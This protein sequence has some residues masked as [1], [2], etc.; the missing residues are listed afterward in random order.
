MVLTLKHCRSLL[1]LLLVC[2]LFPAV[3]LQAQSSRFIIKGHVPQAA[4]QAGP[5]QRLPDTNIL[6]LALGL[7]LRNKSALAELLQQLYDPSSPNF[8][9]YLTPVEFTE[10]FGPTEADYMAVQE[11]ARTNGLRITTT[12][13][14][15]V[16]LD[17]EGASPVVERAFQIQLH[18]YAHPTEGRRFY[19]P[20]REPSVTAGLPVLHVSGLD[21]FSLPHPR[22]RSASATGNNQAQPAAGSAPGGK[23]WGKDFRAAY[24]PGSPLTG[25]GQ[26]VGL[27]QFD[28][29]KA[30][31]ILTYQTNAGLPG[32]ALTVVKVDGG[33]ATPG[34]GAIEVCLDIE[35]VI[36]MAPGLSGVFVYE[37]PNPS[38]WVDLLNAMVVNTAVKQFSCSWGG[39]S[40]DPTAEGIF[41]QMAAQGQSFFNA[42]GDSDAFTNSIPFPGDSPNITQVG[43]TTLSTGSGSGYVSETVWNWGGGVGS[44]GGIS[45]Y[46]GLPTYQQGLATGANQGS[47]TRRN[48][49]DVALVADGIYVFSGG[50]GSTVGGTSAAAPLW[51]GFMALVNQQ[52]TLSGVPVIGFAN[53]VLY[54]LARSASYASVFHDITNG[55][56]FSGTSPTHFSATPGYDLATGLG[57]PN[58][59]NLINA[60]AQP[61]YFVSLTN[62]N[63]N[64]LS[65]SA[66]PANGSIDPGETV[67]LSLSVQNQGTLPTANLVATLL[68]S[69]G[70][71]APSGSQTYGVLAGYG[72]VTNK[73]FTLTTAGGCGSNITAVL[74]L[75]DGTNYLGTVS[76]VLPLGGVSTNRIQSFAQNFDGVIAP[77][78]PE[79]WSSLNVLGTATNWQTRSGVFHTGP[80]SAFVA[81]SEVAGENAL[82]SPVISVLGT[83]AQLAF[84]HN[85]S[86]EYNTTIIGF[87]RPRTYYTNYDGG[88]LEIQIGS[89]GFSDILSAGGSFRSGGYN[90]AITVTSDNPLGGQGGWVTNSSG[91]QSV[92]VNLPASAARQ[93]VQLRWN[94]ATDNGNAGL[95]AVGWYVDS[96]SITDAVLSCLTVLTDVAAGQSLS[97]NSLEAGRNLVYTLSVTN[98]GPQPAANVILTD[99]LPSGSGFIAA[100]SGG[101]YA[102]G[103]IVFPL[104][105][106]GVGASTNLTLTLSSPG[107]GAFTNLVSVG[108]VTPESSVENNTL[109]LVST[110]AS[111]IPPDLGSGLASC[112]VECGSNALFSITPVG[113]PPLALQWSLDGQV[114]AGATNSSISLTNLHLP[115]HTVAIVVTN[116]YGSTT[117]SV[118]VTMADTVAPVITLN[119]VGTVVLELGGVWID[120]GATASDLCAGPVVVVAGGT[121]NTAVPGTNVLTYSASDGNGNAGSITRTVVVRDTVPPQI[122]RCFTNL[123]LAADSSCRAVMPEITGT[124]FIEAWDLSGA[125]TVRQSPTNLSVLPLGTTVAVLTVTDG[126]GNAAYATNTIL[127]QDQTPP[128]IWGQPIGQTNIAAT[129][130]VLTLGATAC[131]PIHY[132]WYFH[133]TALSD[134]TNSSLTISNI[135]ALQAG[136]YSAVA[137]AAGGSSTSAVASLEV[138][139]LPIVLTLTASSNPVGFRDSVSFGIGLAPANASGSVQLFTNGAALAPASPLPAGGIAIATAALPRG[140]QNVTAVY[141]GDELYL[142]ATNSLVEVVTN[143]PPAAVPVTYVFN[144]GVALNIPLP[145]L[146]AG[147]SDP[148]GDAL[149][150]RDLGVST[151]GITLTNTGFFLVYL[152]TNSAPDYFQCL[153]GDEFGGSAQQAVFLVKADP[154]DPTPVIRSGT[155]DGTGNFNLILAGAPGRT[156]VLEGT[157]GLEAEGSWMPFTT[158]VVD[159]SGIWV[160]QDAPVQGDLQRFYRLKLIP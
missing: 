67:T 28:G 75:Q 39:G 121:V 159:A 99:T 57:T 88:V 40:P 25:A 79:G 26:Y 86:F 1:F 135:T 65:E 147:W 16:V 34:S 54:S 116:L 10:R 105:M 50:A 46:Y 37:A 125:V 74:Q 118:L 19:A 80:N 137:S 63:W 12:H 89:G 83:N 42:S 6:H 8:H 33:V 59:T 91:W 148:D 52:A 29:F 70:V 43:G 101:A 134:A 23:Y 108:T 35:M 55:N 104:G 139:R 119:G 136:D 85:Y 84:R 145:A 109:Q 4:A 5:G 32:V 77:T 87:S 95:G 92:L 14:N 30:S 76:Y 128:L 7:P 142:P 31:D 69:S 152:S 112:L 158:N 61:V 62:G 133:Q 82:V 24:A 114:I 21:N 78:L 138:Q 60:L 124:N 20:D 90:G 66:T 73:P 47:S 11:F 156:Y 38:P 113:T 72:G 103:V 154:V 123:V 15:R 140:S 27:L 160:F 120:P 102:D 117:G 68:S 53:P 93:N 41:Q 130:A 149:T 44:S 122:L 98:L 97:T 106:L 3:S 115:N 81:D 155:L 56:N 22:L 153:V 126:S 13:P 18:H 17:V 146:S 144:P 94:C 143:H 96:V 131:T 71:L 132:Q 49:P 45:P 64:L 107:G 111:G 36:S 51:A 9:R 151:N 129:V 141:S 127:V 157:S 100:S 150:L 110:Q 48:V 2:V 58:G